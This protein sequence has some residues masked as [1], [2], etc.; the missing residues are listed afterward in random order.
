MR[1]VGE[2]DHSRDALPNQRLWHPVPAYSHLMYSFGLDTPDSHQYLQRT[3]AVIEHLESSAT[4]EWITA[5]PASSSEIA[6]LESTLPCG[7]VSLVSSLRSGAMSALESA[8]HVRFSLQSRHY[9]L[10]SLRAMMRTV[11]MG[12]GRLGSV[13]LPDTASAREKNAAALVGQEARSLKHALNDIKEITNLPGLQWTPD[14]V[15]EYERQIS[16]VKTVG[17]PGDRAMIREAARLM[18]ARATEAD[19]RIGPA[20]P[21]DHLTWVWHTSSGS[22]H[23]FDWQTRASGDF[24]TDIGAVVSAFHASFDA[25]RRMWQ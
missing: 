14:D 19:P 9:T 24:V 5:A 11:L 25:T 8:A 18:G 17:L 10:T 2:P 15:R 16:E 3:L 13:A 12:A 22:A 1:P 7:P 4:Y 23:V 21:S 6:R 20:A